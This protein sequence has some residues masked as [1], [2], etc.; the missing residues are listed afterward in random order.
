[1]VYTQTILKC[2][3]NSGALLVKCLR[4]LGKS[5]RARGFPGDYIIVSIK[6]HRPH[7]KVKRGEV[8]KGV[9]VRVGYRIKRQGNITVQCTTCAVVLLN[10]RELPLGSRVLG[11]V[12]RE[13]RQ[14]EH[15]KILS[16]APAVI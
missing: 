16:L 11:P 10:K 2:I 13:L 15:F 6:T 8:Y 3:D 12:M 4:I 7:R 14:K 5:P 1:M 9:L